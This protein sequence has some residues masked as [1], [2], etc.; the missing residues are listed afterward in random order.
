LAPAEGVGAGIDRVRQDVM[1]RA[2][3]R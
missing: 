2:V 1:E 3:H